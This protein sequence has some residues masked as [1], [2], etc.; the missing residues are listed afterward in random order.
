MP[1]TVRSLLKARKEPW[2][3]VPPIV[4]DSIFEALDETEL[5]DC[6]VLA[7]MENKLI[8]RYEVLGSEGDSTKI[9]QGQIS[10]ILCQA[11][12]LEIESLEK[13]FDRNQIEKAKKIGLSATNL[14]EPALA[15]A[16][17]QI[18]G[19][20]GMA[21]I[22]ALCGVVEK[23]QDYARR[24]LLVLEAEKRGEAAQAMRHST[25]LPSDLL[26]KAE[27]QL[28]GFLKMPL[29]QAKMAAEAQPSRAPDEGSGT[30]IWERLGR[31][32]WSR[33]PANV[34]RGLLRLYFALAVPWIM[35]FGY[36]VLYDANYHSRNRYVA[37]DLLWLLS[38]PVLSIL[39][40]WIGS[41]IIDGFRATAA[42]SDRSSDPKNA[43]KEAE[44]VSKEAIAI[45]AKL[46]FLLENENAQNDT[47]P[48][49]YR[50]KVVGGKACDQIEGASGEFGRSILNPI[51]V[52]APLGELLYLSHLRV[53]GSKQP[54]MFHRL[55][56]INDIDVFETVTLDG[57]VWDLLYLDFYHP[58]KSRRSPTGYEISGQQR[59]LLPLGTNEF[60]AQFPEG[61][62]EAIS[63][64]CE[65]LI[66]LRLTPPE[67]RKAVESIK[68]A[69]PAD[70]KA[71]Y[72][73]LVEMTSPE[74]ARRVQEF[75]KH[76]NREG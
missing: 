47:L 10:H 64:A 27:Q 43:N 18:A 56:S 13:A 31:S 42:E 70:H 76:L 62:P 48:E 3:K 74:A 73:R 58:R 1:S 23:S 5:L 29:N 37:G 19:Y 72:E 65:R 53:A 50:S 69:R 60:L 52:N 55:G 26:D 35:W 59:G 66:G 22:Y 46:T 54:I 20:I 45:F 6:F 67:V 7:S 2:H 51:P 4:M 57:K 44:R 28:R 16:H 39:L 61:L 41:W 63:N 21:T 24:G 25:V 33:L 71:A 15:L 38:L 40:F 32:N 30:G 8:T 49:F 12:F 17:N 14:F 9:I 68:F 11:G 34:R 75:L 36:Q